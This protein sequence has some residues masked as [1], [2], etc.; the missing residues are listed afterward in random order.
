[1]PAAFCPQGVGLE[2]NFLFPTSS[3]REI[4]LLA[5]MLAPTGM[6]DRKTY[7]EE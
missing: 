3:L 7:G 6:N 4:S 1:M 2:V 5:G